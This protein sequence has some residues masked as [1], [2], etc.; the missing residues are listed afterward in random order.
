MIIVIYPFV[1]A[2]SIDRVKDMWI[3]GIAPL[4]NEGRD[5]MVLLTVP[6]NRTDEGQVQR[7]QV[8]VFYR[9]MEIFL[10]Y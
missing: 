1:P 2:F 9:F 7:P 4:V 10:N 8:L 6:K 5:L 3:S